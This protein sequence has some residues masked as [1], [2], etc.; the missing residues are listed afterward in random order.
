M[1]FVIREEDADR[2]V[3]A[4]EALNLR[5]PEQSEVEGFMMTPRV[6]MS[7]APGT[8]SGTG[9]STTNWG[10]DGNCSDCGADA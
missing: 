3:A 2:V 10:T 7:P 4:V 1:V 5:Q 9:C 8:L 6:K